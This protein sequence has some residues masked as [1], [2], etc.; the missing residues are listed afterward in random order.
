MEVKWWTHASNHLYTMHGHSL[1]HPLQTEMVTTWGAV[2]GHQE[3]DGT[4][5]SGEL[6]EGLMKSCSYRC[7]QGA[8]KP[9]A[10]V[11]YSKASDSGAMTGPRPEWVSGNLNRKELPGHDC[12]HLPLRDR[13]I[14]SLG[15]TWGIN[16]LTLYSSLPHLQGSFALIRAKARG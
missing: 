13:D 1:H 10:A 9:Q 4:L 8:E 12:V 3:I 15:P 6:V 16:T 2:T 5:K 14:P 7:G 11:W